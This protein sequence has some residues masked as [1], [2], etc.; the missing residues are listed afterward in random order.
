MKEET[1]EAKRAER[2]AEKTP[3]QP[4]EKPQARDQEGTWANLIRVRKNARGG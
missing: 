1:T 3:E 4:R 2:N